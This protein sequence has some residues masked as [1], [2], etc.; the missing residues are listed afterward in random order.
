MTAPKSIVGVADEIGIRDAKSAGSIV[1]VA[2][3]DA[4]T[5][6]IGVKIVRGADGEVIFGVFIGA[7]FR[8]GKS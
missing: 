2:D 6:S 5:D 4:E 7:C 1:G 3:R 8:R